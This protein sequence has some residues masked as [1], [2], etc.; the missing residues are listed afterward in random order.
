MQ[1]HGLNKTTL[2]DYSK[3]LA[4]LVF[5]GGCNMRCPFCQNASQVL[6]P[7]SQPVIP[8]EELFSYLDKRKYILEGVCISGGY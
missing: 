5:L 8:E 1:I 2:L 7:E 6:D 3:H 4:A